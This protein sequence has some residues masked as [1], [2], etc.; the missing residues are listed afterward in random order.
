MIQCGYATEICSL[1]EPARW[2]Q[3]NASKDSVRGGIFWTRKDIWLESD[4]ISR[5]RR[6]GVYNP[7]A[8]SLPDASQVCI[9]HESGENGKSKGHHSA[10][11][12]IDTA[13]RAD[14]LVGH[15]T[16]IV[17][18]HASLAQL[19]EQDICNIQ[20]AGSSPARGSKRRCLIPVWSRLHQSGH[21]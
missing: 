15:D 6:H 4:Y 19:A 11:Y 2:S 17:V 10:Y 21:L 3:S 20:V 9:R 12:R 5:C 13:R 7:S 16:V 18:N 14:V 1:M 8:S